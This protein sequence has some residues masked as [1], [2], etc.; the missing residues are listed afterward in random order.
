MH[1][2]PLL[3]LLEAY[4][5]DDPEERAMQQRLRLFVQQ[6][7]D[8]FE[9][10]LLTGH[11]TGS[12]WIVNH[13]H[14]KVLMLHHRKL[15]RWLQP[16]GHADGEPDILAVA[17]REAREETGLD[18]IRPVSPAIFDIDIHTI[19]A[20]GGEP[21]HEHFDV[22][23]L[24]QANEQASLRGNEE[25]NRL[26]WIALANIERLANERSILRMRDKTPPAP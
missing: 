6:H 23:F 20:R 2:R 11:V 18:D 12:A 4:R 1:R 21:E 16:G 8:C 22:R 17:L 13:D 10:R 7:P 15:G 5:T 25:S 24:L 14:S 26:A 9:R 19:P 3:S